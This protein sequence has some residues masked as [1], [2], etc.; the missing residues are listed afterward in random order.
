MQG[1]PAP[2]G[3]CH[4]PAPPETKSAAVIGAGELP[5]ADATRPHHLGVGG[6]AMSPKPMMASSVKSSKPPVTTSSALPSRILSMPLFDRNRGRGARAT[7]WII[8]RSC[9]RTAE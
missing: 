6:A 9:R 3:W 8:D 4:R 7:G 1:R 2:A 5:V